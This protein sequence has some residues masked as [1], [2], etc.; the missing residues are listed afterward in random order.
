MGATNVEL[1]I[2]LIWKITSET[3]YQVTFYLEAKAL[4]SK[5]IYLNNLVD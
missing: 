2:N 5:N 4:Y 3:G 1:N